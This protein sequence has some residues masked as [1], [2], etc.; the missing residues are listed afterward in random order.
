MWPDSNELAWSRGRTLQGKFLEKMSNCQLS[1]KYPQ[2][3][4]LTADY[5][6]RILIVA[7]IFFMTRGYA[8]SNILEHLL[9]ILVISRKEFREDLIFFFKS[10]IGISIITFFIWQL[11]SIFWSQSDLINSI[12][13]LWGWRKIFLIPVVWIAFKR[14][15]DFKLIYHSL[16]FCSLIFC[17]ISYA[18]YFFN[19]NEFWERSAWSV[20]QNHSIQG[21]L[22]AFCFYTML[23]Y[24]DDAYRSGDKNYKYFVF[25]GFGFLTNIILI[26]TGLSGY[27]SLIIF[28]CLLVLF[29]F[30]EYIFFGLMVCSIFIVLTFISPDTPEI[31]IGVNDIIESVFQGKFTIDESFNTSL[32]RLEFWINTLVII[33]DHP[34]LGVGAGSFELAYYDVILLQGSTPAS[35]ITDNPHQQF[36]HIMAE[37]GLIGLVIFGT[38][39]F[40]LWKL[41][42]IDTLDG[43]IF[44]GLLITLVVLGFING[45]LTDI[46]LSR[47]L[48]ILAGLLVVV[49]FRQMPVGPTR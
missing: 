7:D 10:P 20:M 48:Y 37:Y 40:H 38:F 8:I 19:I 24:A 45:T 16:A 39:I 25:I 15:D 46:V 27:V 1:I 13:S 3:F 14:Q 4:N 42:R 34:V 18:M 11:I 49:N 30:R 28:S 33:K 41:V 12:D 43:K 2:S 29:F 9:F 21:V 26:G 6:L 44:A 31:S 36:L 32:Q 35:V 23:L 5:L 47:V 22:F 17:L